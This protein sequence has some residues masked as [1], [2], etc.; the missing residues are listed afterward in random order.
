[1][2]FVWLEGEEAVVEEVVDILLE[3]REDEEEEE[4]D[5]GEEEVVEGK[6]SLVGKTSSSGS[7]AGREWGLGAVS[8]VYEWN[9]TRWLRGVSNVVGAG[10]Q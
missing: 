7:R 2:V 1:M 8:A 9:R 10:G 5:E 4:V 6:E 3:E